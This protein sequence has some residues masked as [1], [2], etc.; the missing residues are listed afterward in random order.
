MRTHVLA[1]TIGFATVAAAVGALTLAS[2]VDASQPVT[3]TLNP[4]PP[5]FVVCQAVGSGTICDGSRTLQHGPID[6]ADE[7]APAFACG[8]GSSAFHILDTAMVDQHVVRY[9]DRNG[10]LTRRVIHELWRS[11]QLSN[12]LTGTALPYKQSDTISDDLAVPGDFD[13]STETIAGNGAI[14]TV[15]QEGA[16]F[17][18]AGRNVF[19]PDGSLDFR[20]G[21]DAAIDYF[22][23][24]DTSVWQPVCA[25]LGAN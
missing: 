25:A 6:V 10:N 21:P 18:Q 3:Q 14:V 12:S 23:D 7:G 17:I 11:A 16:I 15:P 13:T 4:P 8:S 2:N 19:S 24:G 22:V 5:S 9:Y 1:R 20:A